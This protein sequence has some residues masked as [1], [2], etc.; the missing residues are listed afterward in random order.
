[1][2]MT[3]NSSH[4]VQYSFKKAD[5]N[6]YFMIISIPYCDI[7][8][9]W[10]YGIIFSF[11]IDETFDFKRIFMSLCKIYLKREQT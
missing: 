2:F 3:F 6:L 5:N 4:H 10:K 11:L 7:K 1:M 8:C 9:S